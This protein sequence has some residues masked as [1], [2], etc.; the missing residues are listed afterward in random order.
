[1][2]EV[3]VTDVRDWQAAASEA[4]VP[5]KCLS[6]GPHFSASLHA[7]PLSP[8]V[9][10]ARVRSGPV[11]VERTEELARRSEHDDLLLSLQLHSTGQV[12]QHGRTAHLTPGSAALYETNRPY[13]LDHLHPDQDLLVLRVSRQH[14]DLDPRVLTEM[15]GRT[16][17][18]SVPGMPAFTG[19]ARGLAEEHTPL[20]PAVRADL[21]TF[22]TELLTTILRSFAAQYPTGQDADQVLLERLKAHIRIHLADPAL[23]VE[24]LAATHHISL[25]K[26][27][28]LFTAA[29]ITPGA[30]LRQARLD[31]ATRMLANRTITG[32]TIATIARDSGFSDAS[33]FTRAFTRTYGHPP[34]RWTPTDAA[35]H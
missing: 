33:T 24:R 32:Q 31:H 29:G 14:L 30:Y 20:A 19:Y 13:V 16:I 22:S 11:R 18:P 28:S 34:A 7:V 17:E 3:A 8:E 9:S 27:H 21:A 5:L 4:F 10:F 6:E 23:S 15:L 12:H 2:T 25:R 35:L 26:L 1:M